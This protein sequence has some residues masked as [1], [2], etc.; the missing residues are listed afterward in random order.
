MSP[1]LAPITG[2]AAGVPFLAVPPVT[3]RADAPVVVAWH[4]MDPPCTERAFAAAMP[5]DG[6]DAWRIY[7]GLPL[8]GARL[9][10]GG[11]DEVMRLG[12][13]DAVLNLHHP[14]DTQ[15]AAEF[16]AALADLRERLDLGDGPLAL[17]GGSAGS[18]VAQLVMLQGGLEVAAA[19]LVSP[20]AQLRPMV[21]ALGEV[22]GFQYPWH[23]VAEAAAAELDFVARAGEYTQP[24]PIRLI[25]GADDH[26]D[27]VV[28]PARRLHDAVPG[29]DLVLVDGMEHVLAEAPGVEPAPQ[30][31]AAVEA[32]RLAVEWL[33]RHLG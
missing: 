29:S 3:A 11:I 12:Y 32:D 23:P 9:P 16:P 14:A 33:Q 25:V 28:T 27:G 15:A 4:L 17:L 31:P 19:V 8:S 18:A 26:P 2:T 20:L 21:D 1:K 13:E 30:I 7:L 5:L 22:Y 6:M 10:A 24:P